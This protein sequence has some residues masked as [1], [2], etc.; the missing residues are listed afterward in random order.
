MHTTWGI[1]KW[2]AHM[3]QLPCFVYCC[4]VNILFPFG[5]IREFYVCM[6]FA[7]ELKPNSAH[8]FQIM[9]RWCDNNKQQVS[10]YLGDMTRVSEVHFFVFSS[11]V[12][13]HLW[14]SLRNQQPWNF[15]SGA[16]ISLD[17]HVPKIF[18]WLSCSLVALMFLIPVFG[19]ATSVTRYI[20][21]NV[22]RKKAPAYF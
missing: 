9:L 12:C 2:L 8:A 6:A 11:E 20:N 21:Y 15:R 13:P 16:N 14:G 17:S 3:F 18:V 5:V 10:L 7:Q 4:N 22:A 1:S 19:Y